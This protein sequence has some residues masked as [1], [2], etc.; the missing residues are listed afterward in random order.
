L[1]GNGTPEAGVAVAARLIPA[2]FR[3][4]DSGNA[5]SFDFAVTKIVVYAND[6][7]AIAMAEHIKDLLGAGEIE[8]ARRPQTSIDVTVVIGKDYK[9]T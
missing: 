8:V 3:L 2:G 7:D 1:N 5:R 6:A 9:P 4:V